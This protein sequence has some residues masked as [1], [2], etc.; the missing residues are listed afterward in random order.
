MV[1]EE[2]R[3]LAIFHQE[4]QKAREKALHDIHIKERVSRRE[5]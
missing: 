2:Y 3:I 5:T 1:M 4:V